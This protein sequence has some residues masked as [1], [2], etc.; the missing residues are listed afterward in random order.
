VRLESDPIDAN[1]RNGLGALGIEDPEISREI[2]EKE[3][4]IHV[5]R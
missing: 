5:S 2:E 3:K 4:P 1:S